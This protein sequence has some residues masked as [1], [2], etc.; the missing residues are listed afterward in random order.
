MLILILIL[1]PPGFPGG[2]VFLMEIADQAAPTTAVRFVHR[3]EGAG[4]TIYTW[5]L[6]ML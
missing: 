1:V 2:D 4:G 3:L 5:W 6:G